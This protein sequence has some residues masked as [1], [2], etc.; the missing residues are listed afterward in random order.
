MKHINMNDNISQRQL[1]IYIISN[2]N[3][4]IRGFFKISL[5]T[6]AL[7]LTVTFSLYPTLILLFKNFQIIS[8]IKE[9]KSYSGIL[10]LSY[11]YKV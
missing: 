10:F 8:Q 11:Y 2:H 6:L 4:F 7:D 9:K 3:I 5:D 1:D